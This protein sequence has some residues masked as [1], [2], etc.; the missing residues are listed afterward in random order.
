MPAYKY[1]PSTDIPS[2]SSK[3]FLVTG[4]TAGLGMETVLQLAKHDP[5]RI[6]FTGRNVSA[7]DKTISAAKKVNPGLDI[8]FMPCDFTSLDSVYAIGK[9]VLKQNLRLDVLLCNAGVMAVPA[10][11]TKDNYEIQFGIN[12]I[13]H[14]L[15]MK[16]LLPL[17][18]RTASLPNTSVRIVSN[19]SLGFAGS[20]G[21]HL[22][23]INAPGASSFIGR[24]FRYSDAKLANILYAQ[25]LAKHYP[26]ITSV[27]IHPGVI[28]TGL[29]SSLPLFD[30]I[31]VFLTTWWQQID[32]SDG[33]KNQL[34]AATAG[35]GVANGAF[36]EPVGVI[37]RTTKASLDVKGAEK[38]WDWTEK[39]LAR[40]E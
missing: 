30:R 21:I 23:K 33:V 38:L 22:D 20:K 4:G 27:A 3:V 14:A 16:V 37:G 11:V 6:I 9:E 29:V 10:A 15:L 26:E 18:Q 19:T 5:A 1:D 40:F 35:D 31:F 28:I 25:Q 12:H 24:W 32:E 13:A 2:L 17:L 7:A 39:E 34:W 36:Y 8:V